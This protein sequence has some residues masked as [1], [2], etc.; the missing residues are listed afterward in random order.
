MQV[1][2]EGGG[3][4][5][6]DRA[7]VVIRGAR[8]IDGSG[9]PAKRLDLAVK[10]DRIA[11][12]GDLSKVSGDR[13]ID[14]AGLVLAPGFIDVH[15][16]DDRAV[17]ADPLMR[18]KISQGVTSVV[19]GNCGISLSPLS[20]NRSPPPPLD[21]LSPEAASFFPSF[22]AYASRVEADPPAVNVSAQVGHSTLRAGAMDDLSRPADQ[23]ELSQ[24]YALL[25]R[26]LEAGASGLSTGLFYPTAVAAPTDE[27][28]SLA[29]VVS[30][31]GRFHTTHMRDEADGIEDSLEET[32][33]IGLEADVPVVISH[34]KCVGIANHGRSSATLAR[35]SSAIERQD[36]GLDA[37]PYIASSTIL[38]KDMIRLS[39]RVIVAWSTSHP[40]MSG[41]D[42]SEIAQAWGVDEEA[43]AD[44]LGPAGAIYFMM[45]EADVRRILAYP[46]TMIG[47]DGL[48]HDRHPHPRLWGTFPRVL[49]HY[50]RDLG[51]FDLETAVHKMTALSAER[52]GL[53]DRGLLKVG[54]YADLVLFDP[55]RVIDKAT[56]ATPCEPADG[57]HAV[58]VNGRMVW[59]GGEAVGARPGRMMRSG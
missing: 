37:Y 6:D 18:A 42:L 45:D 2:T 57:I 38:S 50:S 11:A 3:Q 24:M 16:H 10:D 1:D 59:E 23:A 19:V 9:A 46:H 30:R 5:Q 29:K 47:S 34:H 14:A 36:I 39:A 51:L 40:E 13:E 31:Y 55:S 54:Y 56:F 44:R 58:M 25:D 48:P 53:R 41:K 20:S 17:L 43:A 26:S 7:D 12:V 33:R 28:I 15:T 21:L 35:I 4:P 8:L 32:F 27:V 22:D 49:G 52:F